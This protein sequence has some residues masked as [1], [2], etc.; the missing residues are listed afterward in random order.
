MFPKHLEAGGQELFKRTE[1]LFWMTWSKQCPYSRI[2][3]GRAGVM[4]GERKE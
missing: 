1:A 2:K 4:D 3:V